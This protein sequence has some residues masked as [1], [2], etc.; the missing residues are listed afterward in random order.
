MAAVDFTAMPCEP[1]LANQAYIKYS[2]VVL[3]RHYG[4][5][6]SCHL[7]VSQA[8]ILRRFES[9]LHCLSLSKQPQNWSLEHS[10]RGSRSPDNVEF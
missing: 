5:I 4:K 7:L 9:H 10:R 2:Y 1:N 8:R 3:V 6:S